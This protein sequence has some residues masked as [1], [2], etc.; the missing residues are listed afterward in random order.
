M[1][2]KEIIKKIEELVEERDT[3]IDK[4]NYW[5]TMAKHHEAKRDEVEK[6]LEEYD[7]KPIETFDRSMFS[8][9]TTGIPDSTEYVKYKG[10]VPDWPRFWA[11][12]RPIPRNI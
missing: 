12:V 1:T 6:E 8:L 5:E 4:A 9:M 11:K 7:W 3:W 10:E 2:V